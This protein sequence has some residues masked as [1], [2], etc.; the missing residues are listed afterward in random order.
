MRGYRRVEIDLLYVDT[1]LTK[2]GKPK[3]R[4][5]VEG[6]WIVDGID[7]ADDMCLAYFRFKMCSIL[8]ASFDI[9]C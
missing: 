5:S 7:D 9:I 8:W 4:Y 1:E 2:M 3:G 6:V